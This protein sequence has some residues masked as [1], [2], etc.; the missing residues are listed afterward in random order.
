MPYPIELCT[1]EPVL[2][3]SAIRRVPRL[4]LSGAIVPLFDVVYGFLR[5][6]GIEHLGI[7]VCV[8]RS[9]T[10]DAIQLEAGVEIRAA[11]ARSREVLCSSTPAGIALRTVHFGDYSELG[12]AHDALIDHAGGL[13]LAPTGVSWE[14]YGHWSDDP[15]Q[16][17]TDVYLQ[18]A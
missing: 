17:R 16:R 18:L 7:N 1:V 8:Y 9:P 14:V 12:R 3:A 11:F 13:S 15:A 2:I 10:K 4:Q 6:R 5:E